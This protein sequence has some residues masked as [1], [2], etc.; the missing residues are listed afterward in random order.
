MPNL[1]K[2][3][4]FQA[5]ENFKNISQTDN[6]KKIDTNRAALIKGLLQQAK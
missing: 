3:H 6:D 5:T 2:I 1:S 4:N